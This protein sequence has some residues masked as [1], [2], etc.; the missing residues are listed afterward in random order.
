MDFEKRSLKNI[1]T[2]GVGGE[3][4]VFY[5]RSLVEFQQALLENPSAFILG[6]GSNCAFPDGVFERKIIGTQ[7]LNGLR[8]KD[9]LMIAEC[10]VRLSKIL[11]F[12]SG[13]PATVGGG[14]RINFGALQKELSQFLVETTVISSDGQIHTLKTL[15]C[16]YGYRT[17]KIK[18]EN[19]TVLTA[20]FQKQ[21][22]YN[23]L[24]IV[25]WRNEKQPLK[26]KNAGS[27]FKNP[28]GNFAGKLIQE[29]GLLGARLGDIGI[30][31][32]HGN[33]FLNY[34]NGSYNDLAS[35]IQSTREKVQE[36]FGILLQ[37]ELE[38]VAP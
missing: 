28:P 6:G 18:K 37:T 7:Y 4:F 34:G 23:P 5:P 9:G 29:A 36:K 13:V 24:P 15:D 14:V 21:A 2:L 12:A 11:D 27:V 16:E 3:G 19:W 8:E 25:K 38:L 10:G 17:S 33:I 20:T 35:L 26:F 32:K 22:D 31:E 1:N 30:W